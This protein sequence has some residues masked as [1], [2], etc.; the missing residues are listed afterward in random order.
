MHRIFA[1]MATWAVIFMAAEGVLG[2]LTKRFQPTLITWHMIFGVFVGIYVSILQ[3]MVMFHFIGSGKEIKQAVAVV[4]GDADVV[5]RLRR[6]KMQVMPA[7]TFAPLLTG[8]GVILGGGAHTGALGGWAWIHW[9]LAA[10]GLLLNLYAFPIE[11]R[12]LV[13]NL[14]LLK[15]VDEKIKRE[16]SPG[17]YHE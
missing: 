6:M 8:A 15:E 9:A 12:C 14:E 16:L 11:Y 13:A 5:K 7:A 10:S 1:G 4:G 2:V 3:V 17:L